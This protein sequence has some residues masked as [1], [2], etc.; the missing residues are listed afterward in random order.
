MQP[1]GPWAVYGDAECSALLIS[2]SQLVEKTAG[3][4]NWGEV[5]HL[6]M[7]ENWSKQAQVSSAHSGSLHLI[8]QYEGEAT[9]SSA[10]VSS[11]IDSV[12]S[13][14]RKCFVM[15]RI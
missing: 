13:L 3:R 2:A 1:R 10:L 4:P 15:R 8:R 9:K 11:I 6:A 5:V 14:Q 12:K 7:L